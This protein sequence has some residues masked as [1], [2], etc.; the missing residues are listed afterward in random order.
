[1]I[2]LTSAIPWD[3]G[4]QDAPSRSS[5]HLD[6]KP[7]HRQEACRQK[8]FQ[9][10][11]GLK[12]MGLVL[13]PLHHFGLESWNWPMDMGARLLRKVL[14]FKE[15][16]NSW[17]QLNRSHPGLEHKSL[18]LADNSDFCCFERWRPEQRARK[19]QWAQRQSLFYAANVTAKPTHVL[20]HALSAKE[21]V[22]LPPE[23]SVFRGGP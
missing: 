9:S 20:E 17:S 6:K 11:S 16:W 22:A 21:T 7:T 18:W 19:C 12:N 4:F 13:G 2:C 15:R 10:D 8:P 23:G 3:P 14:E 1:M 5:A